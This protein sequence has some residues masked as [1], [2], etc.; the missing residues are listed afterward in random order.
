[1]AFRTDF[2]KSQEGGSSLKPE[3][4]YEVIVSTAEVSCTRNGKENINLVYTIRNDVA[5]GY[6]NGLIFHSIWKVSP[7][8]QTKDDQSIGGFNYSNLM[9]V[10]EAA[11]FPKDKEYADLNAFL[12]ELVGKPIKVHLYHDPYNGRTYEKISQHMPSDHPNVT[13][14]P[15]AKATGTAY[16]APKSTQ[17][18]QPAAAASAADDDYPF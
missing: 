17:F 12:A 7:E 2:S 10:A 14:K 4:D 9:A 13:H 3:G 6:Q 18:A 1:M 5:Q 11:Q 16:S 15:K 8:K